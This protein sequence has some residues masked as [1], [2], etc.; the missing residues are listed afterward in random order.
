MS[1]QV[2]E[3]NKSGGEDEKVELSKKDYQKLIEDVANANQSITNVVDEI[4][5]LRKKNAELIKKEK[6]EKPEATEVEKAVQ[7]EIARREK[8]RAKENYEKATESFLG[9]KEFSKENDPDGSKFKAFQ[10]ELKEL[11]LN[12]KVEVEQFISSFEKAARLAGITTEKSKDNMN[13]QQAHTPR[14]GHSIDDQ[15]DQGSLPAK[16]MKLVKERYG[17]DKEKYLKD[18]AKRPEYFD[19]LLKWMP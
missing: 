14:E 17:G 4:K 11:N 3:P 1:T 8:A 5:E 6:E 16:E 19:T 15:G 18:K 12:G 13:H 7:E 10:N 2:P 9:R